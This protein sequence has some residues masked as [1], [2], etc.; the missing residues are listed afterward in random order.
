M[1]AP[2][3]VTAGMATNFQMDRNASVSMSGIDILWLVLSSVYR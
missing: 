2:L 1:K 3:N